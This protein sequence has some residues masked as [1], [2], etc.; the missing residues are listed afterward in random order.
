[1]GTKSCKI[2]PFWDVE[3]LE[4]KRPSLNH[5][6]ELKLKKAMNVLMPVPREHCNSNSIS[7]KI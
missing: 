3:I 1:M 5:K 6:E 7:V 4:N 2:G